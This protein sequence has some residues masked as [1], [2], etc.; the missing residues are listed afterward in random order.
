MFARTT[1]RTALPRAARAAR[2]PKASQ[3]RYQSSGS[4]STSANDGSNSHFAAGLAGGVA[5]ATLIYGAYY[6]SPSG[7]LI[8]TI[9][10]GSKETSKKYQEASQK[11]QSTTPDADQAIN[12]IK[13]FC[14]SYV[15]WVPG[16]RQAVDAVFKDVDTLRQNHR[17][18][19]NQL[20]NDAYRQVQ[21]LSKSG[22]SMETAS[23][24]FDI[25]ADLSKKFGNLAGDALT[26]ILDNHPQIK[27]R[28]GGSLDQLKQMGEE[29]GPEAKRQVDQTWQQIKEIMGSGLTA[30][31]LDKARR[32]VEEKVEQ[33]QKL[34]DEAWKNGMEQAKPY[35][36]KNPKVKELI[37]KNEG[38]LR[39][40]NVTELFQEAKK[41][42][43]SGNTGDLE[44]YVNNAVEKSK[45]KGSQLSS[46]MGLEQYFNMIPNGSDILSRVSQLREVAEK[47][48]DGGEKLLRETMDEL[49]QVLEKKLQKAK[50]IVDKE[51]K[52]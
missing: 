43:E 27:Q 1:A 37:E 48:A 12:Y 4:S 20:V 13:E 34:G 39:R 10:K 36:D 49:K 16:G 32:L 29:Y 23:K 24:A 38:A 2:I 17:D 51:K 28:F 41:V 14:Y 22:L 7:K 46:S 42:V 15:T 47:H 18:E 31:N 8:R 52:Q 9:N 26:D 5:A 19:V 40:G 50:E 44:K 3:I 30:A 45:S 33:V 6:V 35:L 21:D 11:L 25:L